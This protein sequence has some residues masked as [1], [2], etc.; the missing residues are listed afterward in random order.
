MIMKR[1]MIPIEFSSAYFIKMNLDSFVTV[2]TTRLMMMEILKFL[3]L[4][5][6]FRH[7]G[8]PQVYL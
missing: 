6:F 2:S 3:A 7:R 4:L 1:T 8:Q 5:E